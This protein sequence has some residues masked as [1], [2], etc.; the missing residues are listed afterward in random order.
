MLRL[1]FHGVMPLLGALVARDRAAY[2]YLP[3]S[4]DAFLSA[5]EMAQRM[6]AAGLGNVRFRRLAL[7]T[8]TI[9]VGEA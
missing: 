7:G 8:V 6:E 2:T 3:A 1:Y 9:H 5:E 4:V